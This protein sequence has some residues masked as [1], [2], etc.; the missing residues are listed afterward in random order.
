MLCS[1]KNTKATHDREQIQIFKELQL[2]EN[3]G[4]KWWLSL[5][6]SRLEVFGCGD[7]GS[8]HMN[9]V[10]WHRKIYGVLLC[11]LNLMNKFFN[12]AYKLIK[13]QLFLFD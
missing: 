5:Q 11:E 2:Y 8:L 10:K 7:V 3:P 12:Y 9:G 13:K 1:E 4:Y 6:Q